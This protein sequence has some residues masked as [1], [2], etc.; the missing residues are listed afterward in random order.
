MMK[1]LTAVLLS[2]SLAG[3][4]ANAS[5]LEV[6]GFAEKTYLVFK[7]QALSKLSLKLND[8]QGKALGYFAAWQKQLSQCEELL[9]AMNAGMYHSDYT[10]VGLYIEKYQQLQVL[11]KEQGSGNFFLQPN[12]VLAWNEKKAV[13]VQTQDWEKQQFKAAYATQSGPMLVINGKIMSKFLPQSDSKKIRNGVGIKDGQL[14]FVLSQQ[15]VNF[16]E[17][18]QFFK[19]NLGVEQAL[20]LDGSISSIYAPSIK[21]H[22][23][24]Y[25][26]GPMLGYIQNRCE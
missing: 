8:D 20:Y 10:A 21:R 6:Q 15:R 12:G 5:M 4:F 7:P 19:E 16:Y 25:K 9:F 1:K 11:N 26:L 3:S 23:R 24:A 22:D 13:V 17:F 14:Y 18:A 2:L